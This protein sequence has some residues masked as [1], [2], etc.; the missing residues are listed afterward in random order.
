MIHL[1]LNTDFTIIPL[2]QMN[3][4]LWSFMRLLMDKKA[5][6]LTQG[7]VKSEFTGI[8]QKHAVNSGA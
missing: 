5:F 8:L 7:T 3:T 1:C 4:E 6:Y 2:G